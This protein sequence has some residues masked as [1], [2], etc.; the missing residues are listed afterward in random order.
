MITRMLLASALVVGAA[1]FAGCDDQ[2]DCP[3]TLTAGGSCSA[4]GL[5]CSINCTCLGG[6][7]ECLDDMPMAPPRDMT[8][9]DLANPS[10]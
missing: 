9:R 1:A 6:R 7:W 3:S 4:E 2:A 8:M 10:D 5:T